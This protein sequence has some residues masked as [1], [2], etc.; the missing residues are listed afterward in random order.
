MAA[1]DCVSTAAVTAAATAA[2]SD[3]RDAMVN[4]SE[5]AAY[6]E[7]EKTELSAEELELIEVTVILG[8]RCSG[9]TTWLEDTRRTHECRGDVVV[10]AIDD[11]ETYADENDFA[12]FLR[13]KLAARTV[14]KPRLHVVIAVQHPYAIPVF[15]R[16]RIVRV[17]ILQS[18]TSALEVLFTKIVKPS[19]PESFSSVADFIET[20][21]QVFTFGL[22]ASCY[23]I[24][25]KTRLVAPKMS[26]N[27]GF[28]ERDD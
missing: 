25:M 15:V 21:K 26:L 22:P 3:P 18:S 1:C 6:S 8:L 10:E 5:F 23:V 17:N 9:K 24:D 28:T 14:E 11:F 2:V 27:F 7:S 13:E 12:A 4:E 16:P 20:V 19:F